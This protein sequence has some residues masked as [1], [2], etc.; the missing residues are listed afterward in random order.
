[1]KAG[2]GDSRARGP[3]CQC[4]GLPTIST[5]DDALPGR[6]DATCSVTDGASDDGEV[7]DA[8]GLLDAGEQ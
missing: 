7:L 2:N 1:M 5:T 4:P 3:G 6:L 8:T